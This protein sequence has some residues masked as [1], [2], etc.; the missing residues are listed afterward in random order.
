MSSQ[1]V[2]C[3]C[4]KKKKLGSK[5]ESPRSHHDDQFLEKKKRLQADYLSEHGKQCCWHCVCEVLYKT[6]HPAS[7]EESYI[8]EGKKEGLRIALEPSQQ[9][10]T[11]L[12]TQ[13]VYLYSL[14]GNEKF[15]GRI[16]AIGTV[17]EH[18]KRDD[19][20]HGHALEEVFDVIRR[21]LASDRATFFDN[22]VEK[23][24]KSGR[25]VF[26]DVHLHKY[27]FDHPPA[28]SPP[29]QAP[30]KQVSPKQA[31]PKEPSPQKI[32][33]TQKTPPKPIESLD[34]IQRQLLFHIFRLQNLKF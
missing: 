11:W 30:P 27:K 9:V 16:V 3:E 31:P 12:R 24:Q 33:P 7:T 23:V 13:D 28:P 5:F 14:F 6:Q 25:R 10:F 29:K 4:C 1:Y 20:A 19:T 8:E 2:L 21:N 15:A 26:Q 17:I 34:P 22:G 18:H 32:P